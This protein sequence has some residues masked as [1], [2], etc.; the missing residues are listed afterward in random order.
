MYAVGQQVKLKASWYGDNAYRTIVDIEP[1]YDYDGLLID[2]K[3]SLSTGLWVFASN[4]E[5]SVEL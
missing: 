3:V 5:G 4:I 1:Y 2:Q